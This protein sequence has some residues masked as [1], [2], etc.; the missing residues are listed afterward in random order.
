MMAPTIQRGA[1]GPPIPLRDYLD[2]YN[3]A[4]KKLLKGETNAEELFQLQEKAED[5]AEEYD[6]HIMWFDNYASLYGRFHGV[7]RFQ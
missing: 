6:I 1:I 4:R 2:K 3:E 5:T 7:F